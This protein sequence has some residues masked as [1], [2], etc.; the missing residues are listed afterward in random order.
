MRHLKEIAAALD[1]APKTLRKWWPRLGVPPDVRGHGPLKW[2]DDRAEL[3]MVRFKAHYTARGTSL[4]LTRQKFV[5]HS[6][7]KK[8][9]S[10]FP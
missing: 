8:Q 9:L 3:L 5:G 1:C 4:A 2:Q 6:R 10:L 7:D